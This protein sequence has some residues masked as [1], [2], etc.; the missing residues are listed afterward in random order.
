MDDVN[1]QQPEQ[2]QS[3]GPVPQGDG[4]GGGSE[5]PGGESEGDKE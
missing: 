4:D 5:Q 2:P 3:G 1:E